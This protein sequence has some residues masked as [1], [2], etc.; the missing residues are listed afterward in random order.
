[1]GNFKVYKTFKKT[2]VYWLCTCWIEQYW[3]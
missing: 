1:M 3:N 2:L